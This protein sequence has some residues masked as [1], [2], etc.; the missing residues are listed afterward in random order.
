MSKKQLSSVKT[1]D[2]KPIAIVK[3]GDLNNQ[4]IYLC[5]NDNKTELKINDLFDHVKEKKVREQKKHMSFQE[6][7]SIRNAFEYG[8]QIDKKYLKTIYD[9][10]EPEVIDSVRCKIMVHDGI[11]RPLPHIIDETDDSADQNDRIM[12]SGASGSGKTTWIR[13]YVKNYAKLYPGNKIYLLA[14]KPKDKKM[15]DLECVTRIPLNS[16]LYDLKF[17]FENFKNS[18]IIFDDTDVIP[19]KKMCEYLRRFRDN[20][21]QNGRSYGISTIAVSHIL[22]NAK[23]TQ[24]LH[25]ECNK[26]VLY[27][28][29]GAYQIQRYLK[30][31]CLISPENIKKINAMSSPWI[32]INKSTVPT[33][34]LSEHEIFIL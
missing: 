19:D 17:D 14:G 34:V 11:I 15:D 6:M 16:E 23:N 30:E 5:N 29:I 12:V 32:M 1:P 9:K 26:I 18:L 28:K 27:T 22:C 24:T 13:K 8:D 31:Y 33:T 10:L 2:G 25:T 4:I 3:G 7:M 21:I 20:V